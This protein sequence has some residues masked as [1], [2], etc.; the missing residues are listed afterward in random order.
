MFEASTPTSGETAAVTAELP[1][2][3]PS[4]S[5]QSAA[6]QDEPN[7]GSAIGLNAFRA[8]GTSVACAMGAA[9]VILGASYF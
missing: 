2:L 9:I 3:I 1:P 8:L 5:Y 7:S 6:A 4:Y